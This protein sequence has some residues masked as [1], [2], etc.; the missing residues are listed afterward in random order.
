MTICYVQ[1][2]DNNYVQA[3]LMAQSFTTDVTQWQN[4]DDKISELDETVGKDMP[5]TDADFGIGDEHGYEIVRFADGHI[6]TKNFDSSNAATKKSVDEGVSGAVETAKAYTDEKVG[7]IEHPVSINED[8]EDL[9]ITDENNYSIA[10]FIGGHIKTKNFNSQESAT[11]TDVNNAISE[12]KNYTDTHP[13]SVLP[14]YYNDYLDIKADEIERELLKLGG[15]SETF[16]FVT[17][18][19]MN[20]S[21]LR[22]GAV[23]GELMKRVDINKAFFGGDLSCAYIN[24][25]EQKTGKTY[26][27]G[28]EAVF[29]A[30]K[31]WRENWYKHISPYGGF[32]IVHGN[33]DL[34]VLGRTGNDEERFYY[35]MQ[36]VR[37]EMMSRVPND[38]VFDVAQNDCMYYYRDNASQKV[39]V[40]VVDTSR[41]NGL[42][43]TGLNCLDETEYDWLYDTLL[44]TPDGYDIII[45]QHI[46]VCEGVGIGDRYNNTS[47]FMYHL[48]KFFEAYNTKTVATPR[49]SSGN[50]T[51]DFADAKGT[52]IAV[53]GGHEHLDLQNYAN[54]ILHTCTG[55]DT[56]WTGFKR[57]QY[58]TD[59]VV[60]N[61]GNVNEIIIDCVMYDGENKFLSMIKIGAGYNRYF[62]LEPVTI[63]VG[64]SISALS[65]FNKITPVTIYVSDNIGMTYDSTEQLGIDAWN[66][67]HNFATISDNTISAI[68]AGEVVVCGVDE[69][70]NKEFINI[71]I[72]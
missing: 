31:L 53:V 12:C 27:T 49:L 10:Q 72:S 40:V 3:R 13:A 38:A 44:N 56:T 52:I 26:T 65:L 66:F 34:N 5:T 28:E 24:T 32:Y 21:A 1:S 68:S 57:S 37:N 25:M 55:C 4:V 50:K 19:H 61:E 45:I 35:T 58:F 63:G 64:S 11:I 59:A 22:S 69:N 9:S 60:H 39:R 30:I 16:F 42:S 43:G 48:R 51:Y 46:P 15:K 7:D 47:Y 62:N 6:K 67:E 23:I 71:I 2:S 14:A 54:G 8:V 41:N 70:G 17:D 36:Q 33:H 20:S 18:T 29:D